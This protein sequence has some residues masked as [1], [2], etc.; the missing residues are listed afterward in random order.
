MSRRGEFRSA[1]RSFQGPGAGEDPRIA[2]DRGVVG[3]LADGE[4]A[5]VHLHERQLCGGAGVRQLVRD[6]REVVLEQ[7]VEARD[8]RSERE[9]DRGDDGHE[10]APADA[11]RQR[12]ALHGSA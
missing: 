8:H 6:A 5:V 12:S 11:S 3:R 9:P 1:A 10:E 4:L 7:N 2:V